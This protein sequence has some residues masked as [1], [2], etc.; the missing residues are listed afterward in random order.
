MDLD[1]TRSTSIFGD[2]CLCY[3]GILAT[4]LYY[5]SREMGMSKSCTS[6]R[7]YIEYSLWAQIV[8]GN[9]MDVYAFH[10]PKGWAR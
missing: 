3:R 1:S 4:I 9:G 10:E 2:Y 7:I 5:G 8:V 6:P